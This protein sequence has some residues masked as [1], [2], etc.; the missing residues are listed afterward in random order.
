MHTDLQHLI[1]SL[2]MVKGPGGERIQNRR[3]RHWADL[4]NWLS[5]I[6]VLLL[7]WLLSYA[8]GIAQDIGSIKTTQGVYLNQ[9][10]NDEDRLLKAETDV[11]AS[12]GTVDGNTVHIRIIEDSLRRRGIE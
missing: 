9:Q 5:A 7:G 11:A 8:R 6:I 4:P 10:K 12:K 3:S 1:R 2:Q